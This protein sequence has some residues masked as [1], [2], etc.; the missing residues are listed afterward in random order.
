MQ[1]SFNI[2]HIFCYYNLFSI[3]NGCSEKKMG[4]NRSP[5][6]LKENVWHRILDLSPVLKE[7]KEKVYANGINNYNNRDIH[8]SGDIVSRI[9]DH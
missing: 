8:L 6:S 7:R 5:L 4:T 3:K 2:T 1:V 9:R